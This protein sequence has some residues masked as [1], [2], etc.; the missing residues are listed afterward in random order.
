MVLG[1]EQRA[2]WQAQIV[3]KGGLGLSCPGFYEAAPADRRGIPGFEQAA[4]SA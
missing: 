3:T 2:T 4:I 1:A